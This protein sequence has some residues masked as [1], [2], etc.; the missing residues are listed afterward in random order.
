MEAALAV[1]TVLALLATAAS[2]ALLRR[3]HRA[4]RPPEPAPDPEAQAQAAARTLLDALRPE[5]ATLQSAA[6]RDNNDQFLALAQSRLQAE[7]ARGDEQLR[8]R[9]DAIQQDLA[10]VTQSLTAVTDFV[11]RI[12]R[13]RAQSIAGL[14]TVMEENRRTMRELAQESRRQMQELGA[15]TAQ[16]SS[17]LSGGQTR[18]QWGER[19]AEDVLRVAGLHEGLNYRKNRQTG[20]GG[21]RPDYTFLL[22]QDRV[23]HMD[24][25]FPLAGYLRYRDATADAERAAALRQF[26]GDV[27]QRIREVTSR[28]YIDTAAGTLDYMLVFIPNEQVYAFI[29]EQ[30]A[31]IAE[32]A[33]RQRVVLCSP[34]TLFAVL[35][36]IR[37]SVESVRLEQHAN[38]IL[39][40]IGAF[41][42]EWANY[43]D[44]VDKLGKRLESAT[45]AYDDLSGPRTRQLQRKLDKVDA[46]REHAGVEAGPESAPQP[47]LAIPAHYRRGADGD[48]PD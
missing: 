39:A 30:D 2:A 22:P 20:E 9:G 42:Q 37:Q 6:L 36:V 14:A 15:E 7:T 41:Q 40:A 31:A 25:K 5:I 3:Q 12:D 28:D 13:E 16:L 46:L 48:G 44:A 1:A 32:E 24:V 4:R 27:R 10:R 35:A 11:Q 18:G 33:L 17:T 23:L 26:L 8:A 34:L 47:Q 29:H 45:R 38:E 19:M 43:Q 21:G